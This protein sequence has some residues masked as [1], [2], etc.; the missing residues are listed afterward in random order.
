[1]LI[2][3]LLMRSSPRLIGLSIIVSGVSVCASACLCTD[4][5]H[6]RHVTWSLAT[7]RRGDDVTRRATGVSSHSI[8]PRLAPPT[9]KTQRRNASNDASIIFV[10]PSKLDER[11][12]LPKPDYIT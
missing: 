8:F 2:E 10:L 4:H 11:Y 1:M 6:H 7:V 5:A 12:C 9:Y 3:S